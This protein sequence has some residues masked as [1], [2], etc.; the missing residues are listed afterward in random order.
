M[1]TVQTR[2]REISN[3]EG[4]EII[5]IRRS[6]GKPVDVRKNGTLD[7]AWPFHRKTKDSATVA[8][9][10]AKFETEFPGF[11]CIVEEGDGSSATGQK[12]LG[13]VRATY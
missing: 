4:F 5:V 10:R 3:R 8:D 11:S 7:H 1:T 2:V 13:A 12:T 9:F 6:T